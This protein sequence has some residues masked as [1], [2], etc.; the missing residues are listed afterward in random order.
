MPLKLESLLFLN[1]EKPDW[2]QP[3]GEELSFAKW[4]CRLFVVRAENVLNVLSQ[5]FQFIR[6]VFVRGPFSLLKFCAIERELLTVQNALFRGHFI[7]GY[8]YCHSCCCIDGNSFFY[9]QLALHRSEENEHSG[10]YL[11]LLQV[12]T[13]DW[14]FSSY[15][16]IKINIF[17]DSSFINFFILRFPVKLG[18]RRMSIFYNLVTKSVQKK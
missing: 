1:L 18:R 9:R 3:R 11:F 17:V 5:I 13:S 16:E 10:T 8:Y 15:R 7:F 12:I 2:R 14:R 6:V 4:S